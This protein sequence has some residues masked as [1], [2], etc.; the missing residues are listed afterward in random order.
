MTVQSRVTSLLLLSI[1]AGC[2]QRQTSVYVTV[3]A[4]RPLSGIHHLTITGELQA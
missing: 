2:R 1:L 3:D 4:A